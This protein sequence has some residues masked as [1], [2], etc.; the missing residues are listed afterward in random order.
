[1]V[2]HSCRVNESSSQQPRLTQ[3]TWIPAASQELIDEIASATARASA[4]TRLREINQLI[5]RNREI[6]HDECVNLNPATNTLSPAASAALSAGLG[7]RTSLGYAGAKYEMGLEAIERIEIIAAEL[8]AEVFDASY[9][10]VRVPSGAMANLYSFMACAQP[11][12]AIIVPPGSI[13]G[14]VTHHSPGAAGLYGLQIHEAPIDADRYTVDVAGVAE[15]AERVRPAMI[16]IGCSL[17]LSH[18][19]VADLRTVADSVDA[20]LL[21]D[22]AHLSGPIAGGAWPNPLAQGADLLTMST[23]KSLAGPTAGLVV[24]NDAALAERIDAIAFPGMTANFDAGKTAS[25]AITLAEWAEHGEA[26]AGAMCNAAG[27]LAEALTAAGVPVH[28]LAD[29]SATAS[30]AF[31]VNCSARGGGQAT[32]EHLRKANLL[33]SAIGLPS[34]PDDGLRVGTNELVRI[35]ATADHMGDVADFIAR[36]LAADDDAS[37]SEVGR[38]VTAWR[39][40]FSDVHFC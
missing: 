2:G 7:S 13:A 27:S 26:H 18:H 11:G 21:F 6:H 14:H 19:D 8:A 25:L 20:K 9:A 28:R 33:A 17:N 34:G 22:G 29:G 37:L 15:L 16:T 10:E 12:D 40:Q 39:G 30:H 35:G 5:E 36:G 1:M 38:D 3:R 31:A 32:A 24:T 4:T 23:Y